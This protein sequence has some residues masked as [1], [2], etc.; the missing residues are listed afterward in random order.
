MT[1]L[2]YDYDEADNDGIKV[3][4]TIMMMQKVDGDDVE[5]NGDD[6]EG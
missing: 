4:K 5:K 3:K 1:M 6:V 2:K